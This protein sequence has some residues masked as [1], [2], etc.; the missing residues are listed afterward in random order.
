MLGTSERNRRD[1]VV[2]ISVRDQ[3]VGTLC[4]R[5]QTRLDRLGARSG[6]TDVF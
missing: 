6:R 1:N 3:A 4:G 2:T 5:Q